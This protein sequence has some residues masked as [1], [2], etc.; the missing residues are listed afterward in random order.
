MDEENKASVDD[1]DIVKKIS[2]LLDDGEEEEVSALLSSMPR[3]EIAACLMRLEGDK[4]VDA[5][6]LLDR[7]VAL[8]LI[9]ETNDDPE[10]SFL[11]DL[12]AEEISR[13]LDELYA[14]KNDRTVVVDLPPFVIQ[15]MLTHGDSRSKEI[16]EDSITYLMETKQ[17]ALLKSVLVEI[18]PVDIAE[19]LDDFPTE[20]LL[21]IYRIMPKDLASDVFVYLPD[22]VSQKILTALSDTEAGQ[23]IDDLY[24]DDAA[25]LLEEMPSMVVKKLLAKA[26]PETRTAVNHLLQYKEDSAGS[27]MTVEFVD[28]KEYYTAAQAIE[29]I[30]K[31][32]LDKE[33]VNTCFVLDAQRKLLG[34]ITLRKLILA[35]P[36][37][38]VGD[39]MEDNAIMCARTP[40]RKK[41]PSSS[42][43]TT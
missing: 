13:V 3:E 12:R 5:F 32:G 20:D 6:L 34:T 39:M 36:N 22:D 33:T 31:T 43:V 30:R 17:L 15:R 41:S 10:T 25:D 7:S 4:R 27:I 38:K 16:I 1:D 2:A 40:T 37:E 19:I 23:L 29:V 28:L 18:N 21:K 24:A 8:D 14:K 26:K 35:S 11:H 42:S 9:R